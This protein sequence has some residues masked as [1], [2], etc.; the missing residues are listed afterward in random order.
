MDTQTNTYDNLEEIV[1][2]RELADALEV[3]YNSIYNYMHKGG[4]LKTAKIG[5]NV[6]ITKAEAIRF[7]QSPTA[8]AMRANVRARS[9]TLT[10][11]ELRAQAMNVGNGYFWKRSELERWIKEDAKHVPQR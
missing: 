5:N 6:C 4:D 7:M 11:G 10:A 2:I 1:T 3:P 9:R 8:L